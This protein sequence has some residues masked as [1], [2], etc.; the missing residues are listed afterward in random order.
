MAKQHASLIG[1]SERSSIN[2]VYGG[3][4]DDYIVRNT[5]SRSASLR[6]SR[7]YEKRSDTRTTQMVEEDRAIEEEIKTAAFILEIGND[8]DDP[9]FMPHSKETLDRATSF[10]RRIAIHAH[11]CGFAGFGVPEI[12]PA[13]KGSIDLLWKSQGRKLLMNFPA[14]GNDLVSFYGKKGTSELSG[15]FESDSKRPELIYWLVE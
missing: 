3:T 9:D 13:A 15:R 4:S 5:S 11:S 10:L 8:L 2:A 1:L 12:L 6:T 7:L 14:N